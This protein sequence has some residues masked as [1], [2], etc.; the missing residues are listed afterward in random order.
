MAFCRC[1]VDYEVNKV[2]VLVCECV[3]EHSCRCVDVCVCVCVCVCVYKGC[4]ARKRIQLNGSL[5]L[6]QTPQVCNSV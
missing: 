5:T 3:G 1:Q 4:S 2:N 6:G